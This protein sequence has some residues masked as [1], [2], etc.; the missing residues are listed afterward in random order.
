VTDRISTSQRALTFATVQSNKL[1]WA[2]LLTVLAG[3]AM[4]AAAQ[5]CSASTKTIVL[6]NGSLGAVGD[7]RVAVACTIATMVT[8][9]TLTALSTV[10]LCETVRR[11]RPKSMRIASAAGLALGIATLLFAGLVCSQV[12]STRTIRVDN[13]PWRRDDIYE[14]WPNPAG[15]QAL[16]GIDSTFMIAGAGAM[17]LGFVGWLASRKAAQ[18]PQM[19]VG[20]EETGK[21]EEHL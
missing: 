7:T 5:T 16:R 2:G 11:N 9:G 6:P 12:A 18:Q 15:L 21:I 8:G 13:W 19:A 1:L 3:V 14:V 20:P 17:G 4:L 10:G